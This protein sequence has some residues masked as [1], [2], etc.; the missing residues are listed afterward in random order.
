LEGIV[1]EGVGCGVVVFVE[2]TK[3]DALGVEEVGVEGVVVAADGVL[4]LG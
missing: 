4:V 1:G 3:V 2:E